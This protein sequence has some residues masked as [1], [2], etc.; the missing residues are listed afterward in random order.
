MSR[1]KGRGL[2]FGILKTVLELESSALGCRVPAQ[3]QDAKGG[4]SK[5]KAQEAIEWG[6]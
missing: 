5:H 1:G 4:A 2:T 6:S 3:F